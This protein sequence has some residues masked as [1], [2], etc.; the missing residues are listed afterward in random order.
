MRFHVCIV[1]ILESITADTAGLEKSDKVVAVTF[2]EIDRP[3]H[4]LVEDSIVESDLIY[5]A[6]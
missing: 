1:S 6:I 2:I 4:I 5:S 3:A